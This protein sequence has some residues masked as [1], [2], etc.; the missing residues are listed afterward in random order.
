MA[1]LSNLIV[2]GVSR[3][4]SKLYVSDSVTAPTFIGKLQGNADTATNA[5]KVN[6]HTVNADVPSG[7]KFTDTV[8]THPTTSGNKH[9]PSGGSSGQILRWSADGTA[10]W[11]ADNNT[12]YSNFVK[13]GSGAKAGLVPAPSTT[14]GTTKYLREDG[15]WTVPPD[16]NTTYSNMT[17]A[18][19]SAAGKTGL[20]PAPAAGKQTSFLRGDGTWVVPT[21]TTYSTGT[22]STAGLTKLY[23]G[24]GTATDG[25][26]TQTAITTALNGKA[27]SSHTHD[28]RY[29]TES[30]INTKLGDLSSLSSYGSDVASILKAIIAKLP[31]TYSGSYSVTPSAT[32]QSLST[33]GKVMKDNVSVSAIPY[34]EESNSSGTTVTIG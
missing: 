31:E 34:N 22:T 24:T 21:N 16:N 23:T 4:L 28:D 1:Q 25:T 13:S 2:T 33:S 11:G 7:A 3:L 19:A 5:S 9:I 18:T 15:T 20:V 12:T 10:V 17:A 6:N 8:Y 27:A 26:M 30:E 14:A 32:T 29:Y